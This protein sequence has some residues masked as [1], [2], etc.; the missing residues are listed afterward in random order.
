MRM[1]MAAQAQN[2]TSDGAASPPPNSAVA[3]VNDAS[4]SSPSGTYYK[5]GFPTLDTL[6]SNG[7]INLIDY[8]NPSED[9]TDKPRKHLHSYLIYVK[10]T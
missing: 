5:N 9:V 8:P 7:K 2:S 6:K 3:G 10:A 1:P 4:T